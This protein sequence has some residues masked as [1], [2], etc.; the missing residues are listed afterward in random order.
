MTTHSSPYSHSDT[1]GNLGKLFNYLPGMVALELAE[2]LNVLDTG[3]VKLEGD[4]SGSASDTMRVRRVGGVGYARAMTALSSESEAG[5]AGSMTS[6]YHTLTIGRYYT[7]DTSTQLREILQDD[8]YGL[9]QLARAHVDSA[10]KTIRASSCT[11][12]ASISTSKGTSGAALDVDDYVGVVAHF[13]ETEGYDGQEVDVTL[14]P[15]QWTDLKA[16]MRSEPS[17]QF[18]A[19]FDEYQ[20]ARAQFGFKGRIGNFNFWTTVDT[21]TSGS[22]HVGFAGVRGFLG[23]GFGSTERLAMDGVALRLVM[24]ALG[25]VTDFSLDGQRALQRADTNMYM[26]TALGAAALYPQCKI[27]SINN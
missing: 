23:W 13:E 24:A 20:Q 25:M 17:L 6:G 5:A 4:F 3:L 14:H 15:E 22:D 2:R 8:G 16:A 11:T 7:G 27:L 18:P 9:E 26:G 1:K 12:A 10:L 19:K 21:S